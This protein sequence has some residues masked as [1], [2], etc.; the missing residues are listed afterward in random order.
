MLAL[1][2]QDGRSGGAG[3]LLSGSG[4]S[5]RRRRMLAQRLRM[6]PPAAQEARSAARDGRASGSGWSRQRIR[7]LTP[8]DQDA[9]SGGSGCSRRRRRRLAPADQEARSGGAGCPLRRLGRLAP[10]ARDG[11]SGGAGGSLRPI[12]R[13]ATTCS[14]QTPCPRAG[15]TFVFAKTR[16]P[17]F[18]RNKGRPPSRSR[19][20][21]P[22]AGGP[23]GP[24]FSPKDHLLSAG[25]NIP[26]AHNQRGPGHPRQR[27][28]WGLDTAP[29][30]LL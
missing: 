7:R 16:S 22:P 2:D 12:G 4:W 3:C 10:A 18:C 20:R 30:E 24:L 1:A 15:E 28:G 26:Q 9:R 17:H 19:G 13:P 6:L 23:D 29:V 14:T 8:A 25:T 11:R 27:G 5:L 21:P